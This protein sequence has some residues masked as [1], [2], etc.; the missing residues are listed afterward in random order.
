[1]YSGDPNQ[2]PPQTPTTG[3]L[4]LDGRTIAIGVVILLVLVFLATQLFGNR[5]NTTTENPTPEMVQD[6]NA[7]ESATNVVIG[8]V[9]AGTSVDNEGCPTSETTTFDQSDTIYFGAVN[10][11]IPQGTD[12]FARLYF[13]GQ[14]IEDTDVITADADYSCAAFAFE[15]TTGAEVLESGDYEAQL[16]VNGNPGDSASF[17][18]R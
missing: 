18:L 11:D 12:M 16:F 9:L 4:K 5:G 2:T 14:P 6:N 1:M 13:N 8:E 7:G 15:A 17:E 3:G 10:S